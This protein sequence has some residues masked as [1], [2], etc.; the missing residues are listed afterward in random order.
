MKQPVLWT[1]LIALF[2]CWNPALQAQEAEDELTAMPAEDVEAVVLDEEPAIVDEEATAEPVV[3]QTVEEE[4]E[5]EFTPKP[6]RHIWKDEK[7]ESL[8]EKLNRVSGG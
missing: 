2:F 3:E 7:E 4:T 6:R 1:L 8:S 5:E